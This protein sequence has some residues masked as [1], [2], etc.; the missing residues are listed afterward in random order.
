M[1]KIIA[2]LLCVSILFC[3]TACNN[4]STDYLDEPVELDVEMLKA[5]WDKG[6]ITFANGET[7]TLPCLKN[8]IESTSE[9]V[10][11]NA[12]S[13][14]ND[15]I[16]I[17]ESFENYLMDRDTK[18]SA[19]Y[20]NLYEKKEIKLMYSIVSTV[21]IEDIKEGNRWIKFAGTLTTGVARA[22]LEEALGIPE[23]AT[24]EDDTYTYISENGGRT[25]T[26]K[27]QLGVYEDVTYECVK[28][29]LI[30]TFNEKDI[31]SKIQYK[32]EMVEKE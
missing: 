23:G 21:T 20:V 14:V 25:V 29:L 26:I 19:T 3:F 7:L 22:D 1:K 18:I 8:E 11:Y 24:A 16:G 30:V 31:V 9:L 5:N 28:T 2:L 12:F 13:H 6:E 27:D 4:T 15:V 10:M 17:G 32:T